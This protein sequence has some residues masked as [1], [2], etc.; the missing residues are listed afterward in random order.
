MSTS[1][2]KFTEYETVVLLR[3]VATGPYKRKKSFLKIL[4]EFFRFIKQSK[5]KGQLEYF[6]NVSTIAKNAGC[7]VNTVQVFMRSDFFKAFARQNFRHRKSTCYKLDGW[8]EQLFELFQ[9][10]GVMKNIRE[11]FDS[12]HK[13]WKNF[14]DKCLIEKLEKGEFLEDVMNKLCTKSE[15]IKYPEPREYDTL[16]V[17]RKELPKGESK[18]LEI[19]SP[20][21]LPVFVEMANMARD[22]KVR[23]SLADFEINNVMKS[24]KLS[25]IQN[26]LKLRGTWARNGIRANAPLATVISCITKARQSLKAY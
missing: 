8:V 26:G 22:M 7:T 1:S 21:T 6:P 5:K 24:F 3:D 14:I 10:K 19:P 9:R 25:E 17:L 23:F 11:D 18:D 12:F 4:Y 13:K 20:M 16:S 2:I 15:R